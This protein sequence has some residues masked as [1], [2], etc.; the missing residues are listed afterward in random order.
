MIVVALRTEAAHLRDHD[1]VLTGVGKVAAA[2]AVA[3]A[4][5]ERRPSSCSTSAPP[6]PCATASHD[7]ATSWK[8]EADRTARLIAAVV[9]EHL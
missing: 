2:V 1:V 9:D 4:I 5:A 8:A 3:R 6:V 7:A